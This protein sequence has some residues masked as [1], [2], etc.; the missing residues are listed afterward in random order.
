[1]KANTIAAAFAACRERSTSA[2]I[3]YLVAGDP[4]LAMLPDMLAAACDAGADIVEIGFPYSDPLA[5]GPSIACAAYRALRGGA[6]FDRV[7]EAVGALARRSVPAPLVAFTYYNPLLVRGV[8]RTARDLASAGFAGAIIPDLPPEESRP[9]RGA[10]IAAGLE[11][12]FLVAP[13]TPEQRYAVVAACCTGFV[14]VVSRL[15]VTGASASPS[16]GTHA[17]VARVRSVTA[18]PVAVG[19]GVATPTQ[20]AAVSRFADGVI[21]GSALVD[22]IAASAPGDAAGA[23]S[24][25]CS[26]L[27]AAVRSVG[28]ER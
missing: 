21:V 15:G 8:E 9:L 6:T 13:S 16:E 10:F 26:S 11:T 7:L 25:F 3:P 2:F 22:R 19:F 18:L 17:I 20:A 4:S 28:V 14:Y 5:D 24:D 27:A 23:V 1:V 12:A